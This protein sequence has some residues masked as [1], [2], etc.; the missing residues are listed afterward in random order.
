[1]P[2]FYCVQKR[3]SGTEA[4]TIVINSGHFYSTLSSPQLLRGAPDYSTNTV[5]EFHTEA[6]RQL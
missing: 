6:H 5:S 1:M 4:L 3:N 2:T